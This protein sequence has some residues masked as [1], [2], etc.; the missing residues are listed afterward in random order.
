MTPTEY[1]KTNEAEALARIA[2]AMGFDAKVVGDA[3]IIHKATEYK[4]RTYN[5]TSRFNPLV[6]TAQA[7]TLLEWYAKDL[8]ARYPYIPPAHPDNIMRSDNPQRAL[9]IAVLELI[10]VEDEKYNK[11]IKNA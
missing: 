8:S 9:V 6:S 5:T 7:W 2:R 10:G 1:L 11:D 4:G 3:A